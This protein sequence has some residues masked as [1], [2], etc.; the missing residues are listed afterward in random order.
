MRDRVDAVILCVQDK[1]Y[2][3]LVSYLPL[4]SDINLYLLCRRVVVTE[5]YELSRS[6]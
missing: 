2:W 5:L 6:V 1:V 4:L 3:L